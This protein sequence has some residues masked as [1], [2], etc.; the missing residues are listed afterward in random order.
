MFSTPFLRSLFIILRSNVKATMNT[1]ENCFIDF[2]G[3]LARM[4][5]HTILKNPIHVEVK[6]SNVKVTVDFEI[7]TN[8]VTITRKAF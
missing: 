8:V 3:K 5:F 4:F 6:R 2:D 1:I 7:A